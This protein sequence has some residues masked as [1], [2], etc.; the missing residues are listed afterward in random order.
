MS[1]S[2]QYSGRLVALSLVT[3]THAAGSRCP[4]SRAWP[5]SDSRAMTS[6]SSHVGQEGRP[7]RCVAGSPSS[8]FSLLSG[9]G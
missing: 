8:I 2:Q 4:K 3:F 1:T 6:C 5:G 7:V 9:G